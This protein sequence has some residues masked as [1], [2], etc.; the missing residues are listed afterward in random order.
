MGI[1]NRFIYNISYFLTKFY[2]PSN[3]LEVYPKSLNSTN[4]D[5]GKKIVEGD[6]TNWAASLESAE[7]NKKHPLG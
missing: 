7:A 2:T 3:R 4:Y 1:L 6:L 5:F